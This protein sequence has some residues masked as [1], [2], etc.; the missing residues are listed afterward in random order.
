[1]ICAMTPGLLSTHWYRVAGLRPRLRG[2]VRIHRHVYRGQVWYV[3]EDRVAG[4]YYRFNPASYRVICLLDGRRDMDTVWARLTEQLADDTPA[5]DE[6]VNLLG[7]LHTADLIQ[8]DVNPDVAELFERR[9]RQ[10]RRQFMSRYLNPI[11]LRFPLWDPDAFI[12][13]LVRGLGCCGGGRVLF[14][15][16]AVVLPALLLVPPYWPDLTENFTEQ[17]L[18]FDN[19]LLIAVVFPL[20]KALHELGHG[21]AVKARGGDV[22]EMGIMLLAFFPV[23]YVDASGASAFV[24]KADRML[25]GAAGMLTELFIAALAFYLWVLL[26]PGFV[27]SLTYNVIVLASVTTV[28]FNANPLLRYDGYYVLLDGIE[29]PNLGT[30]SNQ[31]WR[32]LA[33]RYLFG[34][35]TSEP[36]PATAGERRW[37]LGYAPLAFAYRMFVALFIALFVAE[38]YFFVGVVLALWGLAANLA[39]PLY[40]GAAALLRDPRYALRAGRVRAVLGAAGAGV[41]LL[42]FVLPVP[43]HTHAEG[44]VWLP[45]QAILRAQES[46][47]VEHV[48]VDPGQTLA[49]GAAVLEA[50]NPTLA[51]DIAVQAAKVEEVHVRRDAAWGVNPARASQLGEELRREQAALERLQDDARRLTL[52]AGA[53]GVLLLERAPDLPG[54]FLRKGD[55]V[56]YVVGEYLP[57]ARVVVPQAEADQV[58]LATRAV[59]IKLPQDL[60]TTWPARLIRQVPKAARDLPSPVLGQGG[61]GEIIVDPR[62]QRL[63]R[64]LESLFEFELELPRTAAAGYI[65]SHVHVRFEH[66][67]EPIGQ[68]LWRSLRRLFMSRFH[69]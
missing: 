36:P 8:C 44:V 43:H 3:V 48:L 40:R 16:L 27:R 49:L 63:T 51:A 29:I 56:G 50:V 31:Y 57:L 13:R 65:G 34:I 68:R 4:K 24:K 60:G 1:M 59:D 22:H 38:Q 35:R 41:L 53:H 47:F 21:I 39:L 52:C 45:E 66:P 61:G 15:W 7:Q 10:R 32:H 46:G 11:A 69:V 17:L 62:D 28:A 12:G 55:V 64:T 19:V 33:D 25:V 5:Q 9:A 2:H 23:P 18:A 54:R 20:V 26:E 14:V 37:F 67:A 30:R 58:R 42:L 6:V